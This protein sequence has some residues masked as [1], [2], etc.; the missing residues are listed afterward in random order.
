MKVLELVKLRSKTFGEFSIKLL[1]VNAT[2]DPTNS[3]DYPGD[4]SEIL[5]FSEEKEISDATISV[6]IYIAGFVAFKVKNSILCSKC[7]TILTCDKKL[8]YECPANV[9]E[10]LRLSSRGGLQWP[11]EFT[12]LIIVHTFNIFETLISER[13]EDIFLN[14]GHQNDLL[15]RLTEN[16]ITSEIIIE[17][18]DCVCGTSSEVLI[19]KCLL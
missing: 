11:N 19:K 16:R 2:S 18:I 9:T 4:F 13:Y 7:I 3:Y 14:H 10:Y 6:L 5:E 8:E 15:L 17:R 12:L 1:H